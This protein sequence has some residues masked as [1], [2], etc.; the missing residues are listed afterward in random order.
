MI[1][2]QSF[3]ARSKHGA[4]KELARQFVAAG[5]PDASMEIAYAGLRGTMS[6]RAGLRQRLEPRRHVHPVA[7]N[8][9]T[10][11]DDVAEVDA[12][13]ESEAPVFGH[14]NFAIHYHP[15]DLDRAAH[16][17]D[18]AGKLHQQ[19][20]PGGL[21]DAAMVLSDFRTEELAAQRFEAFERALL[22][23]P[24]FRY[25]GLRLDS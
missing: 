6:Y 3:S 14:F 4:P 8:V 12:D 5:I 20:V 18:D 25:M 7:E 13:A 17:I 22:V 16:R 23:R 1:D 21:D 2:G 19:A 15:L 11:G 10:I 24:R 9:V